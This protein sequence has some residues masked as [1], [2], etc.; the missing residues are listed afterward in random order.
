MSAT[1]FVFSWLQSAFLGVALAA[2]GPVA[3][4]RAAAQPFPNDAEQQIQAVRDTQA[5]AQMDVIRDSLIGFADNLTTLADFGSLL[6]DFRDLKPPPDASPATSAFFAWI[7]P[8]QNWLAQGGGEVPN[9]Q[10]VLLLQSMYAVTD[11]VRQDLARPQTDPAYATLSSHTLETLG[12]LTLA[13]STSND[14][15]QKAVDAGKI[16][17]SFAKYAGFLSFG[18]ADLTAGLAQGVGSGN[19]K[20]PDTV[21]HLLDALNRGS[22][23]AVGF[24]ASGGDREVADLFSNAAGFAATF[25]RDHTV[26][27]FANAYMQYG[28]YN[29][30]ILDLYTSAQNARLAHNQAPV[31]FEAFVGFDAQTLAAI[32]P[33]QRGAAD[34][35]FGLRPPPSPSRDTTQVTVTTHTIQDHYNESCQS[36]FC[37]R[38]A[39]PIPSAT[40]PSRSADGRG[41]VEFDLRPVS[42]GQLDRQLIDKVLS[43][44]ANHTGAWTIHRQEG[45]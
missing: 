10:T 3:I 29:Q 2:L 35:R 26:D 16:S 27:M 7:Q 40:D 15:L 19:W 1:S 44:Q 12:S 28:G 13:W 25:A 37:V 30:A 39:L 21:A 11:A 41:G 4:P 20:N 5:I 18:A 8:M 38:T 31:S 24:L 42:D 9:Q 36:G 32:D 33:T 45:H 6:Y 43:G 17:Q 22:W 34:A 14:V 23:A